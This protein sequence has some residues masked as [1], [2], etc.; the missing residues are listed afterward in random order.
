M[1][2]EAINRVSVRVPEEIHKPARL[3]LAETKSSFQ[4]VLTNLLLQWV[5]GSRE[6]ETGPS[7]PRKNAKYHD[8]LD[9]ILEPSD[10]PEDQKVVR[11]LTQGMEVLAR[12]KKQ[13]R[14][15][16][17]AGTEVR[18]RKRERRARKEA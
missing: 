17:A 12:I 13:H 3:K 14:A 6:I 5:N 18:E 8:L 7:P 11:V 15:G 10:D 4:G 1:A 2:E 16:G 9:V